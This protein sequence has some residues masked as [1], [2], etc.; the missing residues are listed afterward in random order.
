MNRQQFNEQHMFTFEPSAT[1]EHMIEALRQARQKLELPLNR[2]G[3]IYICNALD[4]VAYDD[5]KLHDSCRVVAGH[6]AGEIRPYNDLTD[7]LS[8]R[9]PRFTVDIQLV[10]L[11]WVDRMI[12]NLTNYGVLDLTA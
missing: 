2:G 8:I 12:D 6:I 5:S 3:Y 7:W 9:Q 4:R 1:V 10:R 11:C